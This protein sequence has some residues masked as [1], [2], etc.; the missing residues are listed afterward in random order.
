MGNSQ[1]SNQQKET[2]PVVIYPPSNA[3]LSV[4]NFFVSISLI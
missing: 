4:I 2:E 3:S 1:S